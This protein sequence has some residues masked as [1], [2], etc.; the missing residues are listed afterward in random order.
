L[1]NANLCLDI[2]RY[3]LF[4]REFAY[5]SMYCSSVSNFSKTSLVSKGVCNRD[6]VGMRDIFKSLSLCLS[7]SVLSSILFILFIFLFVLKISFSILSI[8]IWLNLMNARI[9]RINA[10]FIVILLNLEFRELGFLRLGEKDTGGFVLEK[11]TG[12]F[13][14]GLFFS[15]FLTL[16]F[17]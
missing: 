13:V 4:N 12:G 1:L 11:G 15:F 17:V 2:P 10:S 5:G 8:C 9:L 3:F 14:F 16:L 6:T 7:V